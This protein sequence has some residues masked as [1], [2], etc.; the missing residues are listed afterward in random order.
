L[1]QAVIFLCIKCIA[2][3]DC[4]CKKEYRICKIFVGPEKKFI[5]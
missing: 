5:G 3:G 1:N 2:T 4:K